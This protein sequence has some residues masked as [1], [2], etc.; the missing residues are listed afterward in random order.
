M[1]F[2]IILANLLDYIGYPKSWFVDSKGLIIK[3][4]PKDGLTERKMPF[5]HVHAPADTL[6][7]AVEQIKPTILVGAAAI[8]K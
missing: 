8:G 1:F 2:C 5:A 4:C 3:D 6:A 7:E